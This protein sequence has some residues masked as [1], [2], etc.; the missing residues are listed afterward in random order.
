MPTEV[1]KITNNVGADA[2]IDFVAHTDTTNYAFNSLKR[3]GKL[4]VV[5]IGGEYANFMLPLIPI[6]SI[7]IR[8][9]YVGSITD[10]IEV[11]ELLKK[12]VIDVV[13]STYPLD[14]INEVFEKFR[15]G[16][17]VGRAILQP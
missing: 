6:K 16:K 1:R 10:L 11:L 8:G 2:A 17:I 3:G 7:Q 13:A 9:S 12:G 15:A 14:Q 5:G 4:V